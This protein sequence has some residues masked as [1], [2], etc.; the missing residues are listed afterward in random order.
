MKNTKRCSKC[1][2]SD[3]VLIPGKWEAGG[4]GNV[5]QPMEPVRCGQTGAPF[6]RLS[7]LHGELA[8]FPRG[9]REGESDVRQVR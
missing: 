8:R 2:S 1:Q 7:R 4:T 5:I 6:L 9:Y 3:I